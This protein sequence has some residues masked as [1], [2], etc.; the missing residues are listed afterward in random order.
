MACLLPGVNS[1]ISVR[2]EWTNI[3][4]WMK[5]NYVFSELEIGQRSKHQIILVITCILNCT[6]S[7]IYD[8][9]K[10]LHCCWVFFIS[11]EILKTLNHFT[12]KS[13]NN[14]S[15]SSFF[16]KIILCYD[17]MKSIYCWK[18][19][20]NVT[21]FKKIKLYLYICF[22]LLTLFFMISHILL[23]PPQDVGFV[24]IPLHHVLYPYYTN[25]LWLF[26]NI[27]GNFKI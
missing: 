19:K 6:Y 5:L 24:G 21:N 9:I 22:Y 10:T 14:L 2:D 25:P 8:L 12:H 17:I 11:Q 18:K 26:Q 15:F 3:S 27:D 20:Y 23:S 13:A 7:E 1:A 16:L 4:Q